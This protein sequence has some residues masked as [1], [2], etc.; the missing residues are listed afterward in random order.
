VQVVDAR[1]ELTATEVRELT[2]L[3][4]RALGVLG[5]TGELRVRLVGDE[6]MSALHERH[7]GVPGTTDVLT[8]DLSEGAGAGERVLD[9]DVV[10]CVDEARRR[11]AELGHTPARELLLYGVHAALHCLGHDD[12][13][14]AGAAR[15]HAEEDRVLTAIGVGAVYAARAKAGAEGAP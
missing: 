9:A 10:L 5:A 11:A 8:F 14:E 12:H 6:E 3:L 2:D 4:T 7:S 15:M 1:G 13:D